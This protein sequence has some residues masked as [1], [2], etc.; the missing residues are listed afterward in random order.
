M[1]AV[2]A[3]QEIQCSFARMPPSR[4]LNSMSRHGHVLRVRMSVFRM[5]HIFEHLVASH[6]GFTQLLHVRLQSSIHLRL[7]I[8][9]RVVS[10][11]CVP[12]WICGLSFCRHLLGFVQL[13]PVSFHSVLR[14][15]MYLSPLLIVA[16]A[17]E[18]ATLRCVSLAVSASQERKQRGTVFVRDTV[19]VHFH[20]A[21]VR[22]GSVSQEAVSIHIP[23]Q[24]LFA[25]ERRC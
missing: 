11:R 21:G 19:G 4:H 8:E 5:V 10:T 18:L 14:V 6:D 25:L 13:L 16:V 3:L 20:L 15:L 23:G 22:T 7:C 2:A 24:R 1:N 9:T 12:S 17:N